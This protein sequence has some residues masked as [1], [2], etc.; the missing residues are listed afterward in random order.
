MEVGTIRFPRGPGEFFCPPAD[1]Q[2][3]FDPVPE[4]ERGIYVEETSDRLKWSL[5]DVPGT[6]EVLDLDGNG[7]PQW[8]HLLGHPFAETPVTE[9]PRSR[10]LLV[11]SLV[12]DFEW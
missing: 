11:L 9:P 7:E 6:A 5:L 3:S 10:M 2:M 4:D 12:H 8:L 1:Y